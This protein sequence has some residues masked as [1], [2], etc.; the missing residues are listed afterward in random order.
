MNVGIGRWEFGGFSNSKGGD[1]DRV[2]I[3]F[4]IFGVWVL[5]VEVRFV[6]ISSK[7]EVRSGNNEC[8]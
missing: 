7:L 8:R 1:I 2:V 3:V 6:W 5:V 4:V